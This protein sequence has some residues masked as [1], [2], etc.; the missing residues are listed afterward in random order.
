MGCLG[1]S[2]S[3]D[4]RTDAGGENSFS[5]VVFNVSYV[6]S[7]S[8]VSSHGEIVWNTASGTA[9]SAKSSLRDAV[10]DSLQFEM[11]LCTTKPGEMLVWRD[12]WQANCCSINGIC[13]H[14]DVLNCGVTSVELSSAI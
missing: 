9:S 1:R 7:S 6:I 5:R 10:C 8:C 12:L 2:R 3:L 4:A 11:S 13:R 14:L